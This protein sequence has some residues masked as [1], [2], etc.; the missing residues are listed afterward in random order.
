MHPAGS[1]DRGDWFEAMR[2][3]DEKFSG[4]QGSDPRGG[5]GTRS[6]QPVPCRYRNGARAQR[7]NDVR[8]SLCGGHLQ[9]H[10]V[11]ILVFE[12]VEQAHRLGRH[13]IGDGLA[14]GFGLIGGFFGLLG[15]AD[16]PV[17]RIN[18]FGAERD[19]ADHHGNGRLQPAIAY[20]QDVAILAEIDRDTSR[21][22]MAREESFAFLDGHEVWQG[23]VQTKR[24]GAKIA[25][26]I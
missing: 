22:A 9:S 8:L 1:G 26:S 2:A 3:G 4:C 18:A 5:A 19:S 16:E 14:Q 10:R 11:L 13:K 6:F 20:L 7:L 21:F 23:F 17:G 25:F 12:D 15:Q 24:E